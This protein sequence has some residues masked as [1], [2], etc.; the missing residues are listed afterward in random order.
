MTE[1]DTKHIIRLTYSD[2]VQPTIGPFDTP[3][4]AYDY[5]KETFGEEVDWEVHPL[6]SM[7]EDIPQELRWRP[8]EY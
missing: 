8:Y 3:G 6:Y 5:A 7:A 2:D 4:E 1:L